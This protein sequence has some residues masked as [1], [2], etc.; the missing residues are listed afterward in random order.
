MQSKLF[1]SLCHKFE[2]PKLFSYNF[3]VWTNPEG[4]HG[5]KDQ[6]TGLTHWANGLS[7]DLNSIGLGR[8]L[9]WWTAAGLDHGPSVDP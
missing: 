4:V 2:T 3:G 1:P 9:V 6:P 7:M 5:Q 8:P